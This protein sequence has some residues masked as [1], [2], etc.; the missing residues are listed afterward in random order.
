[1]IPK[2]LFETLLSEKKNVIIF[3]N[4]TSLCSGERYYLVNTGYIYGDVN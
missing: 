4:L 1:M 2:L 3:Q